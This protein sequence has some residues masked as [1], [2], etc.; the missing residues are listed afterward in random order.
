MVTSG[1]VRINLTG[2]RKRL[3]TNYFLIILSVIIFVEVLFFGLVSRYYYENITQ[4]LINR[5]T[6]ST[7]FYNQFLM[8]RT[9]SVRALARE[10][11]EDFTDQQILELQVLDMKG[12]LLQSST[13][14]IAKEQIKTQDYLQALQGEVSVWKGRNKLTMEKVLAV[15]SPLIYENE[16]VVGVLRYVTSLEGADQM[17][18]R[19]FLGSLVIVGIILLFV[20][21]MSTF[22]SRSIIQPVNEITNVALKMA[23]G[24][25]AERIEK[26]YDDEIGELADT[27][28]YMASEIIRSQEL[29]NDFV[30]SISH[31]LRTPLT[32][33]QGWTE[34]ILTGGFQDMV[35]TEKGLRIILKETGRLTYMVEE[36]LDFSRMESGRMVLQKELVD[37]QSELE[38]LILIFRARAEKKGIEL[39]FGCPDF[40]PA[41]KADKNRLR[42]VLINIL[43]NSL[44]FIESGKKIWVRLHVEEK[45]LLLC[46]KDQ[47]FGISEADLKRVKEKFYK[48]NLK[49]SGSGL[50]LAI[51]DEIIKLHAG[52]LEIESEEGK[53]TTVFIHLPILNK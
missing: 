41:I 24:D 50:G 29:K 9:Q 20:F 45:E 12:N 48:G 18:W 51:S 34:T 33:I 8:Q 52:S 28:N 2:L 25:F 1:E 40:V 30:S 39:E 31:E 32:S 38:E 27:L 10:I 4:N 43:D 36:L 14:F 13:G 3:I 11:I 23:K 17:I 53:G 19:L 37:L 49:K 21:I 16:G 6:L 7:G 35:E 5:A 44:K 15:S 42:Q 22:F 46:I 26:T 47:G